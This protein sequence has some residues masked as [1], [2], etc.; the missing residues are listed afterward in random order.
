MG[1][2]HASLHDGSRQAAS[3]YDNTGTVVADVVAGEDDYGIWISGRVR[4]GVTSE[5]VHALQA[6]AIS[7][8]WRAIGGSLELIAALVVNVPGFPVP[9]PALAADAGE[10][11][12]LVAAG[13]IED[14]WLDGPNIASIADAVAEELIRRDAVAEKLTASRQA[15]NA[16]RVAALQASVTG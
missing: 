14:Q 16:E 13:I 4:D 12:S 9:R 2:G 7:G 11:I 15:I 5:Q 10:Q 3:H 1:T 8:D 6:G